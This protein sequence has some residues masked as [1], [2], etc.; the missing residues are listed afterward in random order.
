MAVETRVVID[1]DAGNAIREIGK[2]DDAAADADKTIK[3][4]DGADIDVDTK[5]AVSALDKVDAAAGDADAAINRIDKDVAVRIDIDVDADKLD[6]VKRKTDDVADSG[7]AGSTAIGGIGNSISELPGVGALGPIAE[8]LGQ[9]TENALEGGESI[10]GIGKAAALLGGTALVMA[11]IQKAMQSIADT[12]AFNEEQVE[13]FR[14]ALK[15]TNDAAQAV[16]ETIKEAEGV[17]GRAGGILGVF[18]GVEDITPILNRAKVTADEWARAVTQGGPA[19]DIVNN[20]LKTY[21]DRIKEQRLAYEAGNGGALDLFETYNDIDGALEIVNET[22]ANNTTAMAKNSET[23]AFLATSTMDATFASQMFGTA[24][25]EAADETEDLAR[26][27]ENS[28]ARVKTSTDAIGTAFDRVLGHLNLDRTILQWNRG[29]DEMVE[30]LET[31]MKLSDEE[32][33]DFK[34]DTIQTLR[35]LNASPETLVIFEAMLDDADTAQELR[36]IKFWLGVEAA[37]NPVRIPVVPVLTGRIRNPNG[38]NTPMPIMVPPPDTGAPQRRGGRTTGN[39]TVNVTARPSMLEVD[40]AI[41]RWQRIN[42]GT[43]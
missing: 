26:A 1:A 37:K 18:E 12:D 23:A 30:K 36:D 25:G 39:L 7:R 15:E 40:G 10:A 8:S 4:L 22:L 5:G 28:A 6:T 21:Q 11:G 35:D 13:N 41:H 29:V 2:L 33:L 14:D 43:R 17:K 24:A 3:E 20:K 16:L 38:S 42:G 27:S 19:L 34:I 31:G 9:L 32:I